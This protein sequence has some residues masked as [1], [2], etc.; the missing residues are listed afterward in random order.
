MNRSFR[1]VVT[2]LALSLVVGSATTFADDQM[3]AD[4]REEHLAMAKTYTDKVEAWKAEVVLHR[5][6]AAAY[7]KKFPDSKSGSRNPWA[8]KMEKHCGAIIKDLEK[9]MAD[10]EWA[11]KFHAERAKELEAAK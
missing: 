11:A 2:G 3:V 8:V 4:T 6:M 5:N 7:A 10:A 9:L 1:R